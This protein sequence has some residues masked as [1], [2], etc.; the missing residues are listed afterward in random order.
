MRPIKIIITSNLIFAILSVG[1]Y[2]IYGLHYNLPID[3]HFLGFGRDE[4]LRHH[5]P[6]NPWM[7]FGP[8]ELIVMASLVFG[9]CAKCNMKQ[10]Q[11]ICCVIGCI[12]MFFFFK[13]WLLATT[14]TGEEFDY[15][16]I[17]CIDLVLGLY[18]W[19]SHITYGLLALSDY[20]E[21]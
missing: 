10:H 11:I 19:L 13:S 14:Y 21:A 17:S 18:V 12:G 5:R 8:V 6:I 3:K 4:I 20:V 2:I 16:K 15:L 1:V 9:L 7:F